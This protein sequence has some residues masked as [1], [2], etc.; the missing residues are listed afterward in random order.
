MTLAAD[1]PS[2]GLSRSSFTDSTNGWVVGGSIDEDDTGAVLRTTDG[3]STWKIAPMPEAKQVPQSV[4]FL[5]ANNGWL[6]TR[7]DTL[8]VT[9]FEDWVDT[10]EEYLEMDAVT[11]DRLAA[12][13]AAEAS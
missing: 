7:F 5:D 12:A 1:L 4:F 11:Q 6:R 9:Q 10:G 2:Y 3:G 8:G 13:E